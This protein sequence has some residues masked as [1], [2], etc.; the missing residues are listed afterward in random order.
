MKRDD[1]QSTSN[2]PRM[3]LPFWIILLQSFVGGNSRNEDFWNENLEHLKSNGDGHLLANGQGTRNH[4]H[5]TR[6]V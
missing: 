6:A 3:D 1:L 2:G 5:Y 4:L